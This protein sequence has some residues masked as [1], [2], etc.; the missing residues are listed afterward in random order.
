MTRLKTI[1]ICVVFW[2]AVADGMLRAGFQGEGAKRA[3]NPPGKS[4]EPEERTAPPAFAQKGDYVV[5]PPDLL[6]LKVEEALPGRPIDGARLVRP[7]GTVS[8]GWYGD[9]DV[10]GLTVTEIKERLIGVLQKFIDDELLGLVVLDSS[11]EAV[12]DPA[13]GKPKQIAPKDSKK[14]R[15]EIT[16]CNSKCF[17]VQ[18]EVRSPGRFPFTGTERIVDAINAAGGLAPD[19]GHNQVYLYR[20]DGKGGPVRALKIDVDQMMLGNNPSTNYPLVP[21][22]RLVAR[23]RAGEPTAIR[24]A[25]SKPLE[26]IGPQRSR[27]D[28]R[29]DRQ[30]LNDGP[31]RQVVMGDFIE[32]IERLD[33]RLDEIERKINLVLDALKSPRR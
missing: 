33:K 22:D 9:L 26:P 1:A 21:G 11:G 25:T 27:L 17:Y 31:S 12:V 3:E 19:A 23:R 32:T 10:A 16:Q 20:E 28:E 2:T 15:V 4:P 14:V 24:N 8:L 30:Q 7:D 13:T 29:P 6:F 18:G 5:E